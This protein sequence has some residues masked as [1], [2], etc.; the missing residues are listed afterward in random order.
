MAMSENKQKMLR[1]ELYFAFTDELIAG[2]S[3]IICGP[4]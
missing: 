1:G 3:T 4:V 2:E